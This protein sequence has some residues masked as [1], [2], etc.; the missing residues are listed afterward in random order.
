[1]VFSSS[2]FHLGVRV[3]TCLGPVSS[4]KK[5]KKRGVGGRISSLFILFMENGKMP[6]MGTKLR[7]VERGC[8]SLEL[9]NIVQLM[10]TG[11]ILQESELEV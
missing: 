1:M 2:A 7:R 4:G 3:A 10:H 8:L 6:E 5:K 11:R 9:G